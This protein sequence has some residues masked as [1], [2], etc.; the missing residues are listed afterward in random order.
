M[1]KRYIVINHIAIILTCVNLSLDYHGQ[2][3]EFKF[4]V[5]CVDFAFYVV[6]LAMIMAKVFIDRLYLRTID[7]YSKLEIGIAVV[8]TAGIVYEAVVA[9]SMH[10][11]LSANSRIEGIFRSF[12]YIR[13]IMLILTSFYFEEAKLIFE[14]VIKAVYKIKNVFALWLIVTLIFSVIGYHLHSYKTKVNEYGQ[15]DLVN[16]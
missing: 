7:I 14:S 12:K 13:I 16:G 10:D 2:S 3:S 15:L 8:S 4:V 9:E 6:M 5:D 1:N 11:F